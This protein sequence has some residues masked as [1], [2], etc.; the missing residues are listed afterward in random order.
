MYQKEKSQSLKSFLLN[1][2]NHVM[3]FDIYLV[4]HS[5]ASICLSTNP[6]YVLNYF[7]CVWYS[8]VTVMQGANSCS[9]MQEDC[10]IVLRHVHY[11]VSRH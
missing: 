8:C 10:L 2:I 1:Q 9:I 5:W 11:R 4:T 3:T 7:F 6:M